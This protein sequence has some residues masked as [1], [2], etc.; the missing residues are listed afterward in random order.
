MLQIGILDPT[1]AHRPV[2]STTADE[3]GATPEYQRI[4]ILDADR[5]WYVPWIR[6]NEIFTLAFNRRDR[7]GLITSTSRNGSVSV[8]PRAIYNSSSNLIGALTITKVLFIL[9]SLGDN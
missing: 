1:S 4:A 3:P 6:A 2:H 7:T 8:T 9:K 5:R